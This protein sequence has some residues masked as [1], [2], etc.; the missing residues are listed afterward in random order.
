MMG[1]SLYKCSDSIASQPSVASKAVANARGVVALSTSTTLERVEI[2]KLNVGNILIEGLQVGASDLGSA[3]IV[4]KVVS[5]RQRILRALNVVANKREVQ[6]DP[7]ISTPASAGTART[8]RTMHVNSVNNV[9]GQLHKR[10]LN[11]QHEIMEV[12]SGWL[13]RDRL[14]GEGL[15]QFGLES[16][17]KRLRAELGISCGKQGNLLHIEFLTG[18]HIVS[19][20]HDVSSVLTHS[21]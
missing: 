8:R 20:I 5:Y 7:L 18:R 21:L 10:L 19:N 11:L 15:V 1:N 17:G 12:S 2:S 6:R 9:V 3:S 4:A 16:Q 14:G 13:K